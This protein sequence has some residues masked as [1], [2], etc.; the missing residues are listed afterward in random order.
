MGLDMVEVVLDV[1]ETFGIKVADDEYAE[2]QLVGDFHQLILRH[3]KSLR[4]LQLAHP[5]CP[6]IPP[7]LA[8][9]KSLCS[10]LPVQRN[11]L[12]PRTELEKVIPRD[13]RRATWHNLQSLTN[14]ILPPLILP[15]VL[16]SII[17]IIA[18]AIFAVLTFSVIDFI[19]PLGFILA[20]MVSFIAWYFLYLLTRPLAV[21]F[22]S[23]C[24]T[25]SDVVCFARPPHY[26]PQKNKPISTDSDEIWKR[27]VSIIVDTLNVK[28]SE[29][30]PDTHF[31]NDLRVG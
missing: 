31:I 7:F 15:N 12:R 2:I 11:Q 26:P 19:G 21:A 24:K 10:L 8:L 6:S 13:K 28:E 18:A 27:L 9:R 30:T 3:V 20:F 29:V 25:I 5:G 17:I 23:N 14:I 4:E 1:E 22:P 16:R